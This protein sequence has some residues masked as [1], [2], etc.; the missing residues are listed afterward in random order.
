M[1]PSL[2]LAEIIELKS[3]QIVEGKITHQDRNSIQIDVG[4]HIPVT[5]FFDEIKRIL[6]DRP[7]SPQKQDVQT[8]P[9]TAGLAARQAGYMEKQAIEMIN[10]DKMDEGVSLMQQAVESAPTPMRHMNYGSVLFGK[11]VKEFKEGNQKQA[12]EILRKAEREL[13]EAIT[14]FDTKKDG[15]FLA[16]AYFLLGEI[17]LNAY[18]DKGR[19]KIFYQKALL[20]YD[21]KGA[22]NALEKSR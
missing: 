16:Q 17:Y 18:S 13:S 6:P 7:E 4:I 2:A 19:A 8:F 5:Y 3:G 10:A 20:Y 21:H 15:V 1:F 9:S 12:R 14:G 11:G 22:R